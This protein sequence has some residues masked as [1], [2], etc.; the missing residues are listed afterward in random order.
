LNIL[1]GIIGTKNIE[2]EFRRIATKFP[3]TIKCIPILI[4][5]RS[6]QIELASSVINFNPENCNINEICKFMHE[7]GLFKI[8]QDKTIRNLTDYLIGI[9]VGLDT[10]ARKNRGGDLMSTKFE[11]F[12]KESNIV[13]DKE[14]SAAAIED[15]YGLDLSPLTNSGKTVKRFDFAFKINDIV[16]GVEVNFYSGGGSK[17]NETARSYKQIAQE[18]KKIK[19]FKFM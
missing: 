16:Y 15:K 1:N 3:T 8:L 6:T 19:G 14:I 18:S 17:L 12:L 4:A 2:E 9:E 10:N 11:Q 13:Y 7:C 5:V